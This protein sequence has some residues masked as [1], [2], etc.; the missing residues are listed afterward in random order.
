M[1][2]LAVADGRELAGVSAEQVMHDIP[3]GP[4]GPDQVRAGQPVER[5]AGLRHRHPEKG[6]GAVGVKIVARVQAC[7]PERARGCR[8]EM[9]VRPGEDGPHRRPGISA[10]VQD[11]QPPLLIIQLAYEG[12]ERDTGTGGG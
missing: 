3:A 9:A 4:R 1:L 12:S 6:R 8:V 5:L 11:V 10:G 2:L 7:Q